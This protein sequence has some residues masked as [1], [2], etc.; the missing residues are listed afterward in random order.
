MTGCKGD[1]ESS[2]DTKLSAAICLLTVPALLASR[3]LAYLESLLLRLMPR[4]PLLSM[5]QLAKGYIGKAFSLLRSDA[6]EFK[7]LG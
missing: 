1:M 2:F 6:L 5:V 3:S 4:K 7:N